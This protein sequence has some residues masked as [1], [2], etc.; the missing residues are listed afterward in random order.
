[1]ISESEV[2]KDKI[3]LGPESGVIQRLPELAIH[4]GS[5]TRLAGDVVY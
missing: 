4:E 1:M 3:S 5:F 2:W